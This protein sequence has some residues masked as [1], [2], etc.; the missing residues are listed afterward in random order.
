[1]TTR[2]EISFQIF[3][4]VVGMASILE[5]TAAFETRARNHGLSADE[6]T[7]LKNAG[8]NT[9][10]KLVFAVATPGVNPPK[11]ELRKLLNN[12]RPDAVLLGPL[13]SIRRLMF[14]AQ[15]LAI[16]QIKS[17]VHGSN[18]AKKESCNPH[19]RAEDKAQ[20]F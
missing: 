1:M 8:V 16:Q 13:S 5:A 4:R 18:S 19:H 3:D 14:D 17:Q 10:A 20:W 11:L 6:M 7:T 15:T 2:Q 12:P 9:L